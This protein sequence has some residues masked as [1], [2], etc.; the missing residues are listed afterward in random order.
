MKSG[1]AGSALVGLSLIAIAGCGGAPPPLRPDAFLPDSHAG[2]PGGTIT[3]QTD[4]NGTLVYGDLHAPLLPD[5]YDSNP[6]TKAPVQISPVVSET[7]A[8]SQQPALAAS[9]EPATQ[10]ASQPAPGISTTYQ[11]VGT[12]LASINGKPVY[13]DEV[14]KYVEPQL[15]A[16]ARELDYDSFRL[17]AAQAIGERVESLRRSYLRI[18][19]A[20]EYLTADQKLQADRIAGIW[21]ANQVTAAGGSIELAKA[22]AL[23]DGSTLDQQVREKRDEFLELIYFQ[24]RILPLVDVS[25]TAMRQYYEQNVTA[26][27][28]VAAVKFHLIKIDIARRGGSE[29]ALRIAKDIVRKLR[30]GADFGELARNYGTDDPV[31]MRAGGAVMGGAWVQKGNYVNDRVEN[32]VWQLRP[33]EFSDPPIEDHSSD[34]PAFYVA[35]LDAKKLGVVKPL[36]DEEV[37]GEIT[38]I[39]RRQQMTELENQLDIRLNQQALTVKDPSSLQAAIDMAMERYALWKGATGRIDTS[40]TTR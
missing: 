33:T 37:Q 24:E 20:E 1:T 34:D 6:K 38:E 11:I 31:L 7:V 40:P 19:A 36:E 9:T 13:A 29:E 32:A 18:A 5:Q 22:Q 23:R 17:V 12:V 30:A 35:L 16:R 3:Q 8:A 10:P 39:L 15:M 4:I 28:Q 27:T 14:L 2:V 25:P 26:F 21:L